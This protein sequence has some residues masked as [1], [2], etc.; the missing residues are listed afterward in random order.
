MS[1]SALTDLGV[2]P[3]CSIC[4]KEIVDGD[5]IALILVTKAAIVE[6]YNVENELEPTS[7]SADIDWK[8]QA[9]FHL[10]CMKRASA[11]FLE[12]SE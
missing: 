6:D 11:H 2:E 7:V 5:P 10:E 9:A 12:L 4:Q 3:I 8:D 1:Y